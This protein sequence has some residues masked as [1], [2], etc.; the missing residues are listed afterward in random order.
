MGVRRLG[1]VMNGVTGRMGTNQ[2]LVRSIVAI[3]AQGG[4][5]LSNG[6]RVMPDPAQQPPEPRRHGAVCGVVTDDLI[7][8]AHALR[9]EPRAEDV[10]R[11]QRM[12]AVL[13]A[14]GTR[15]V[16][17][18]VREKGA[19]DVRLAILPLAEIGLREFVAAI[20]DAPLAEVRRELGRRD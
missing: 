8:V 1:I 5:I 16:A 18:E 20:E 12:A 7:A 14:L 9:S 4:V 2:H 19:R 15:E 11:W 10:G 3:R 17:V 13:A 6:D